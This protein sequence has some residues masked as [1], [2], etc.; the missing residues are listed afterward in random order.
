[1]VFGWF[2]VN[3]IDGIKLDKTLSMLGFD[4]LTKNAFAIYVDDHCLSLPDYDAMFLFLHDQYFPR[5]AFGPIPL[6]F[7]KS[8]LFSFSFNATGYKL[9]RG[10]VMP[11]DKFRNKFMEFEKH[12]LET[13]PSLWD[14]LLQL[15][16]ITPFLRVFIPGRASLVNVLKTAFSTSRRSRQKQEKG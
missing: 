4:P 6:S 13:P 15:L 16:Y 8:V 3:V 7:K 11:G 5:V 14:K 9:K 2:P 1:M 10:R 12:W